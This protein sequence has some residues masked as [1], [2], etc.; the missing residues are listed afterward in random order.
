MDPFGD[1]EMD[2][3]ES[4]EHVTGNIANFLEELKNTEV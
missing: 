2:E 3:D 1:V 4:P